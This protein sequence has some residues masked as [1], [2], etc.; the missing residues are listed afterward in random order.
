MRRLLLFVSLV[1]CTDPAPPPGG[2]DAGPSDAGGVDAFVAMD[3]GRDGVDAPDCVPACEGLACGDDGCGGECGTCGAGEVCA[4]GACRLPMGG[5]CPPA[6][7]YGTE[8]G[9]VAADA[10]LFDC[11]GNE[12]RLHELCEADVA[13]IFEFAD[14]CPPCRSFAR[15]DVERIWTTYDPMGVDG[16]FVISADGDFGAPDQ[17]LCNE[18]RDRYSLSMPVLFDPTGELQTALGINANA[19]NVLLRPGGV[20]DWKGKYAESMV[21]GMIQ[22]RLE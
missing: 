10:V 21:E 3:G 5:T 8:V 17:A 7:P 6:A 13:W 15:D 9:D 16:Y 14:W 20:I 12:V 1:A 19:W 18:I 11:D 2:T 4:E 22:S